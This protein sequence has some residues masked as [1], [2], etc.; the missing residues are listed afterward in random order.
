[1]DEINNTQINYFIIKGITDVPGLQAPIFLL[2]LLIYLLTLVGNMT[3]FLL[4]CLDRQ[5]H[6]PMYFFLGNLAILDISCSTITLHKLLAMFVTRNDKIYFPFCM[7]QMFFFC[8]FTSIELLILTAMSYDRYV[9]ICSPLY[10]SSVMNPQACISL[11]LACWL[12]GFIE[13]VPYMVLLLKLS[14]YRSNVINHFF[15]D[16]MPIIKLS[17]SDT[18]ALELLIFTEGV[19]LLSVTPFLLTLIS[20]MFIITSIMEIRSSLG[21]RKTFYTC[22]SHLTVVVLLYGTLFCQ[23]LRPKTM[24]TLDSNKMFSLFNT[25]AVPVLNPIIYSLKN[26]AVKSALK[27]RIVL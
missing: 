13:L 26:K 27:Q 8:S 5:L 9:A 25:I 21:R 17:C 22:S 6:N 16:I 24:D 1:M 10:Y 20:Y 12:I 18:S 14:C 15:C 4:I 2:V 23:Y 11:A 3:I 19:F 7:A